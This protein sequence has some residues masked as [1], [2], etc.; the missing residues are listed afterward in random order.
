MCWIPTQRH[1]NA[2]CCRNK[3]VHEIEDIR[4][5]I[6]SM[7]TQWMSSTAPDLAQRSESQMSSM[8]E[9]FI[10]RIRRNVELWRARE[11]DFVA[12]NDGQR[13][14]WAAI[15]AAGKPVEAEVVAA[16]RGASL[17]ADVGLLEDDDDRTVQLPAVRDAQP[18]A[19]APGYYG[20]LGRTLIGSLVLRI[21]PV[22]RHG[23]HAQHRQIAAMV[24]E[25]AA[26]IERRSQQLEVHWVIS[27]DP[28]NAQ[29]VIELSGGHEAQLADEFVASVMAQHDLQQQPEPRGDRATHRRGPRRS[30]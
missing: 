1:N 2:N 23:P 15:R 21:V 27:P 26:D 25:L 22:D 18:R 13:E 8:T 11:I 30:K 24:Y 20:E 9:Q 6:R 12:F 29:I 14:I 17:L 4:L 28:G 16:L 7:T 3:Q 5:A 19:E 10:N